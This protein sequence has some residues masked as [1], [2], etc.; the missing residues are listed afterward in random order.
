MVKVNLIIFD[1]TE[2]KLWRVAVTLTVADGHTKISGD[3]R[4][5][6]YDLPVL[7][8]RTHKRLYYSEDPEEWA[9]NLDMLYHAPDY[10]AIIV[11]DTNP[12]PPP[13]KDVPREHIVIPEDSSFSSSSLDS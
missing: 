3:E 5:I 2:E 13:P 1:D 7:N 4:Y 9:R 11:R 6:D 8:K 10:R 12:V